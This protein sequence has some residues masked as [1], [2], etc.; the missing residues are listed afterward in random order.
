M[1]VLKKFVALGE[2]KIEEREKRAGERKG[3]KYSQKACAK[4][5]KIKPATSNGRY[6]S[7][8]L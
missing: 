7:I 1:G 2:E 6:R 8:P 4:A 5:T 3:K